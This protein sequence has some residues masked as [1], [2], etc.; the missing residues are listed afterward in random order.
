[1]LVP[2]KKRLT[3]EEVLQHP[4]MKEEI[5]AQEHLPISFDKFKNFVSNN[6]FKQASLQFIASQMSEKELADLIKI[7]NQLDTNGDGEIS[8]EEFQ[9]GVSK[10]SEKAA[11]EVQKV[12]N[13]LDADKNGSINYTEFIAATMSQSLY[14]Q[15]EKI[16]QAFKLFDKNGDGFITADEIKDVLGSNLLSLII[17]GRN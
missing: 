2:A 12:F 10:L 8:L 17:R 13:S 14:L 7:F 9:N 11:N 4:W 5:A 3:S 16:Y 1:M 6:K 15:E